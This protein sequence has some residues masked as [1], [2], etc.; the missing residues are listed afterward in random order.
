MR[1]R[2]AVIVGVTLVA[3]A[4]TYAPTSAA[5][6]C[7][8]TLVSRDNYTI[9]V[10][11]DAPAGGARVSGAVTVTG[12]VTVS[13][14]VTVRRMTF[15]LDGVYLLADFQAPYTFILPAAEV[16][17]GTHALAVEALMRD[18]AVSKRASIAL[19]KVG[20]AVGT[21]AGE[22]FKPVSP[23]REVGRPYVV[24]A[25]GDGAGG[26][27]NAGH[28][29]DLIASWS[30]SL[31]L[32][33]G[34]VYEKGTPTEFY[35]WY[36]TDK[37]FY[38]RFASITNPTVGD[39]EYEGKQADG[40]FA[41]WRE[42]PHYYSY[43]AAGW[44]FITL[45]STGQFGETQ[46]GSAQVEWLRRDLASHSNACTLVY[47][48]HPAFSIGPTGDTPRMRT[49]WSMLVDAHVDVVLGGNDHDY[50]RWKPMGAGSHPQAGGPT[51][52]VV[53]TG[54]HAIKGFTR[55]DE[56]VVVGEDAPPSAYGALRLTLGPQGAT[57]GFVS[58]SGATLDSGSLRCSGSAPDQAAP[59]SPTH[60]GAQAIVRGVKLTWSAS[61][62]DT[63]VASY[64][65]YR[66]A[67]LLATVD[68][69][70]TEYVDATAQR[71]G[72]YEYAVEAVD[73]GKAV[74]RKAMITVTTT[75]APSAE[76]APGASSDVL[77][78]GPSHAIPPN[79]PVD[80]SR[81]APLL[82]VL[83]A[84][85]LIGGLVVIGR[86]QSRRERESRGR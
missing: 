13:G 11:I 47:Y 52:F 17:P 38:G 83:V 72:R 67:E 6:A 8:A 63:A 41:Y 2:L 37:T 50:Q 84:G 9:T 74:S 65:I 73:I 60:L 5:S 43:D 22:R 85:L 48:Q 70:M 80:L 12:S 51:Q 26:E 49:V 71:G 62:D 10:C 44:H 18:D 24:A 15:Y 76:P 79:N 40:Y 14:N 19:S 66:G 81:A 75:S 35:N 77:P 34:D 54:G 36:G 21:P 28:V 59:T 56:R 39:H 1:M 53:G 68:A 64:R 4:V 30:P 25:V 58:I 29:T 20:G 42:P 3:L 23:P 78:R 7:R 32:Y 46:A 45:D 82:I 31:F 33:L 61:T 69:S 27:S 55:D 57:Y 86:R 16:K